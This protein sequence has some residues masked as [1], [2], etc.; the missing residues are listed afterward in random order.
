[1]RK[2]IKIHKPLANLIRGQRD[3]NQI[4]KI[5]NEKAY[6]TTETEKVKKIIK[7]YNKNLYSTKLENQKEMYNNLDTSNKFK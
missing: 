3:S 5:K 7:S 4:N 2:S 1:L 6:I